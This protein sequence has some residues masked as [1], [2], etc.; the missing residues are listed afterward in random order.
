MAYFLKKKEPEAHQRLFLQPVRDDGYD[1]EWPEEPLDLEAEERERRQERFSVLA[2]LGN[3]F[4]IV[5][6]VAA[7]LALSLLALSLYQWVRQDLLNSFTLLQA[8]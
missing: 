5:A 2:T 6:A 7:I 4:S 8:R 1:E 3:L